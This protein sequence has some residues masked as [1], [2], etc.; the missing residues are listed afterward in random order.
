MDLS[1]QLI[2]GT[3]SFEI[4]EQA[5]SSAYPLLDKGDKYLECTSAGAVAVPNHIAFGTWEF[6]FYK[7]LDAGL[8][9]FAFICDDAKANVA[10]VA[11]K[12]QFDILSTEL[13]RI[14]E[15]GSSNIWTTVASYISL[16]T[17][18]RIRITRTKDG[19]FTTYIKGGD[20]GIDDWTTV[21][22]NAG[23]NPFTDLTYTKSEYFV[24][25]CDPGDRIANLKITDQV[26]Q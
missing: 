25:D 17:W 12:Y 8:M 23:S 24:F 9:M 22:P 26:K 1:G 11:E 15:A 13:L 16:N 3:G 20:F 19:Q 18:Y 14:N 6:D 2:A 5:D 4:K 10:S 21:V 7:G